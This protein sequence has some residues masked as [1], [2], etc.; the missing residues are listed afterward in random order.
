V[1]GHTIDTAPVECC[2]AVFV[3][4]WLAGQGTKPCPACGVIPGIAWPGFP[5]SP[6]SDGA[7]VIALPDG[8]GVLRCRDLEAVA[9]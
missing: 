5:F 9:S 8:H 4:E 3:A 7:A 1:A 2:N 6:E